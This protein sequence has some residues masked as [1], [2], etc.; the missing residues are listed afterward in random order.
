MAYSPAVK[1]EDSVPNDS[2][3]G[4]SGAGSKKRRPHTK[5]R[6]GCITCKR[7]RVKC[8]EL[9]PKCRNCIHL[10][11]ECRYVESRCVLKYG[12]Q[13]TDLQLLHHFVIT[14]AETI[15]TAGIFTRDIWAIDVPQ[16][17][18]RFPFLMH[19]VLMFSATHLRTLEDSKT[20]ENAVVTHRS[21][22]L[23]LIR[24]EVQ[25]VNPENLDALVAASVL[26]ILDAMANASLP[27]EM[28]LCSLPAATW[29]HHVRGAAIIL[30]AVGVLPPTSKFYSYMGIDLL[31]LANTQLSLPV[32]LESDLRCCHPLLEDLYPVSTSSP[33]FPS[34]AYLD[35]LLNQKHKS[36]YILRVFSFPALMD[37]TIVKM[38]ADGDEWAQKIVGAYYQI[39]RE[40]CTSNKE[41]I[42][43]LQGVSKVLPIDEDHQFGGLGFVTDA[44]PV[45]QT[46]ESI[47]ARF[48]ASFSAAN[49]EAE[50]IMAAMINF[51]A[52]PPH[53]E[54]PDSLMQKLGILDPDASDPDQKSQ[55]NPEQTQEMGGNFY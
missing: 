37:G 52:Q 42:W 19:S 5:S 27:T 2:P 7:R 47:L 44:L 15:A 22:S 8:D 36:D 33:Y 39:V 16:L 9:H 3:E 23:R 34:L 55:F 45:S 25:N 12:L 24:E 11:L 17:G 4:S 29:L 10:R 50:A 51:D 40:Y 14:V 41:K 43:F 49:N 21:E 13:M 31:D 53:G 6:N 54:V 18:V 46:V 38:L 28:S 26:M 30:L 32:D 20:W 1:D 48:D 35:K